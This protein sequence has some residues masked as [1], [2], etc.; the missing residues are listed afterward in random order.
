MSGAKALRW[1]VDLTIAGLAVLLVGLV[2][3][4]FHLRSGGAA[5]DAPAIRPGKQIRLEDVNWAGSAMT[6]VLG[7]STECRYCTAS[8]P[9]YGQLSSYAMSRPAAFSLIAVLPESVDEAR[10][11]FLKHGVSVGSIR[12]TDLRSLGIFSTPTLLLVD[13]AG[14]VDNLWIGQLSEDEQRKVWERL[15]GDK[16]LKP[17]VD[18]VPAYISKTDLDDLRKRRELWLVDIRDREAYAKQ[19]RSGAINIPWHEL[20]TRG[21]LELSEGRAVLIAC[22]G[23]DA[24]RCESASRTLRRLGFSSVSIMGDGTSAN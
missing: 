15:R 10:A 1:L 20:E 8:L 14:R 4:R 24:F 21:P 7:L 3:Q 18:E 12:Q 9:F 5:M 22:E 16:F 23:I 2:I 19:H 17:S 13:R 11:Y 6:V